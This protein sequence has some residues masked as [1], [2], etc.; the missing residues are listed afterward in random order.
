MSV[1]EIERVTDWEPNIVAFCCKWCSYS[2]ADLAGTS[3]LQ[4]PPQ[5]KIIKVPCSGRIDPHFVIKAFQRGADGVLVAG[6][7]PGDCHYTTGNYYTRRRFLVVKRLLEYVGLDEDRF[8]VS[9]ISSSEALKF[10]EMAERITSKVKELGPN[11][12]MRDNL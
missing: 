8:M 5:L 4:Y 1:N 6:C 7:H 3:R 12:I 11:R 10:Q 2:G 9:W